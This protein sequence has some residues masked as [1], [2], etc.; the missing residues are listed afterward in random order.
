MAPINA[1][2]RRRSTSA[3]QYRRPAEPTGA[4]RG[5]AT[6]RAVLFGGTA[7]ALA[8]AFG[9]LEL[10]RE[11]AILP[12]REAAAS[13]LPSDTQ[14]DLG[15]FMPAAVSMGGVPVRMPPVHTVFAT[16]R[17]SRNPRREDRDALEDAL[18]TVEH[19]YPWSPAGIFLETAYGLPYFNR[20]NHRVVQSYLPKLRS[21]PKRSVLEEAVPGPTDV[22]PSNPGI[23][24]LRFNNQVKIERNDLLFTL[25]GDNAD[26]IADVLAWLG[27]SDRLHHRRV[28]SP[29]LRAGLT[30]TSSRAMFVQAGLPRQLAV[31]EKLDYAGRM[32]PDSP[33]FMG[34]VSQQVESNPAGNTVTFAGRQGHP[35]TTARSGDYFDNGAIQ[36]LAHDILD[37]QAWYA[38]DEPYTERVQYMFRSNPIP[39]EGGTDQFTDS[40]GPMIF[41]AAFH[42]NDDAEK[43][44]RGIKT[45]EGERRLG[46][47][48]CLHRSSRAAD[49]TPL[50]LRADGPGYDAM[51]TPGGVKLPKLQFSLYVPT[52]ELMANIRRDAASLDLQDKFKVDPEDNGLERFL[53]ATRRQNFLVPPRRHRSFPLVEKH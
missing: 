6:R 46:H 25:R 38:D 50:H 16:A 35:L 36:H 10:L 22:H 51:D 34:F 9:A 8:T 26:I 20:L 42:G 40:G 18:R 15:H 31:A 41:P 28:R 14:F 3:Y 19:T 48:A 17:L 33:M 29:R 27:G 37:L 39:H 32:H 5:R 30:F 23:S 43:A 49:G 11:H 1:S 45:F 21:D 13:E 4:R 2:S 44:A 12:E 53:T 47:L 52:A 24:K 7:A